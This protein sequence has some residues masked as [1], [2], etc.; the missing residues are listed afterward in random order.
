MADRLASEK[1]KP[2]DRN[3]SELSFCYHE[4]ESDPPRSKEH[5]AVQKRPQLIK[6][7]VF[8]G[9]KRAA[10]SIPIKASHRLVFWQIE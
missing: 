8:V 6:L 3:I 9:S 5:M 1:S 4:F 7:I 2:T 10:T